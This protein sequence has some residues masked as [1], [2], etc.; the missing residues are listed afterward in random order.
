MHL[1][2]VVISAASLGAVQLSA[3]LMPTIVPFAI[4]ISIT[5]IAS[6]LFLTAANALVQSSTNIGIRGRVM[7]LYILVQLGGMAIGGPIM[8]WI[9][10]VAGPHVGMVIE[11]RPAGGPRSG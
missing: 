9:V 10:E 2:T 8:G 5:G 7:A 6:L 3:G 4:L 1:R 11:V